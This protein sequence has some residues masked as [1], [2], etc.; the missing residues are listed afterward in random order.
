MR[1]SAAGEI[2]RLDHRSFFVQ[3]L[4]GDRTA[5]F[6][7]VFNH[8]VTDDKLGLGKLIRV[9]DCAGLIVTLDRRSPQ[10]AADARYA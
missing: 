4:E 6:G 1:S 8:D 3:T 9:F 5:S 10:L 7:I 2:D